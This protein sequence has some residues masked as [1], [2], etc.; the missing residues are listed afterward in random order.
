MAEHTR[1]VAIAGTLCAPQIFDPLAARLTD[2]AIIDAVSWMTS[3]GPWDIP[4]VAAWVADRIRSDGATPVTLVGHSTGGAIAL[5]LVLDHPELV[6]R[7]VLIDSGANM[8]GH[9]DVD[10]IIGRMG[11]EW[12]PELFGMILDRSFARPL[13]PSQRADFLAYAEQVDPQ[14]AHQILVSQ[15]ALDFAPRLEEIVCPVVV[16]HGRLDPTRSTGQAERFAS[17]FTAAE[18]HLL[19]CGHSPMFELPEAVA[20][21]VGHR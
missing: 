7:L 15:R 3:P 1:M 4:A 8:H 2:S 18:L 5:Q 20:S 19:E 9:G 14:A 16:I 21:I 13:A 17:A 10:A 12:G 6:D 11:D